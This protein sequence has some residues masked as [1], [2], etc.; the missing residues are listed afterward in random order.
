MALSKKDK[1]TR[2]N[3][4]RKKA[5][6]VNVPIIIED[7]TVKELPLS[8]EDG[9]MRK[10]SVNTDPSNEHSTRIKRKIRI[11]DH[12]KNLIDLLH[13]RLVIAHSLTGENIKTDPN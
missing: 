10:L 1:S 2:V 8:L 13:A 9:D 12:P 3:C 11:W 6:K 4:Y 7:L 5:R